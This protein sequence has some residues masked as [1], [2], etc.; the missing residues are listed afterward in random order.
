[1]KIASIDHIG[2]IVRDIDKSLIFYRDIL[3]LPFEGIEKNETHKLSIAFLR[4]GDVLV[5]LLQPIG[6][7]VYREFLDKNGEGFHHIAF[8]ADDITAG[9][10]Y[11]KSNNIPLVHEQPVIGGG[12]ALI[13]FL[14]DAAANN[15]SIEIIEKK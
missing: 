8:R 1:M 3:K 14:R 6:E 4:C 5:E 12:G 13:A 15:V 2:I 11:L 7:G 9:L 10:E